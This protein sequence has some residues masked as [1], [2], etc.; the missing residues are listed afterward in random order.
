MGEYE[1]GR[2]GEWENMRMGEWENMRMGECENVRMENGCG[3][4]G[5]GLPARGGDAGY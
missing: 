5:C 4:I 1:N 3:Q 2:I